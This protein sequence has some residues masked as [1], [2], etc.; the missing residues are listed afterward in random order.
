MH[1]K[2]TEIQNIPIGLI[3]INIW[4]VFQISKEMSC[5]LETHQFL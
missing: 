2:V 3:I 4:I 5:K 1:M